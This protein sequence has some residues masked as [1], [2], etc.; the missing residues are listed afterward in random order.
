M[1]LGLLVLALWKVESAC[2]HAH[3]STLCLWPSSGRY[4]I[5]PPGG[6]GEALSSDLR[7][8]G[9]QISAASLQMVETLENVYCFAQ[10][11]FFNRRRREEEEEP[12]VTNG[13]AGEEL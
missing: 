6:G 7:L 3:T 8:T 4:N 10:L 5:P 11:G 13:K 1:L 12:P 9:F 2:P